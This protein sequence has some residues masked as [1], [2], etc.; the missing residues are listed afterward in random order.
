MA[1]VEDIEN[2]I[3]KLSP[4]DYARLAEWFRKHDQQAWDEQMDRDA[5]AGKLDFIRHG[6]QDARKAGLV[7]DFPS[8]E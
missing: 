6:V 1:S 3:V 5:A 4:Q 2:A 8:V 7:R